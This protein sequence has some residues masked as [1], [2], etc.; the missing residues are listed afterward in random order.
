MKFRCSKTAD[1]YE[2][3]LDDQGRRQ[4]LEGGVMTS[5]CRPTA[6]WPNDVT[7][8][9]WLLIDKLA[10]ILIGYP[11]SNGRRELILMTSHFS[12]LTW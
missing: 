9:Y 6:M 10:E 8:S 2:Y 12:G 11:P 4:D 5:K 3:E 1:S 7:V